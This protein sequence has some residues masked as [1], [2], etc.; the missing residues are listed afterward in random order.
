MT[1]YFLPPMFP[2]ALGRFFGW[3]RGSRDVRGIAC[4]STVVCYTGRT[5]PDGAPDFATGAHIDHRAGRAESQDAATVRADSTQGCSECPV[6]VD[7]RY[8]FR[9]AGGL[10]RPH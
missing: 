6:C 8:G 10:W 9:A 7:R 2:R 3:F 1:H 5:Q 4:K